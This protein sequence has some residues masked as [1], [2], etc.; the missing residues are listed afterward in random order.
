M[1]RTAKDESL[2]IVSAVFRDGN[3]IPPQYTC[4]GQNV[5]PPINILN[6]PKATQSITLIM[7]D[8][9]AT[10]GDFLHWLVWD[11]PPGTENISVNSVPIGARQGANGA[12]QTGY[13]GPCPPQGTGTHRYLFDFYALDTTLDL[14]DNAKQ[15]DVIQAQKGHVLAHAVLMGT[16]AAEA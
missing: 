8:P 12:G 10:S 11:I 4:K 15:E 16:F 2:E 6:A 13:T 1:D 9:D 7:H 14:P 5:N 3:P